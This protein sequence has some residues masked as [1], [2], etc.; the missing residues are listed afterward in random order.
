MDALEQVSVALYDALYA[1]LG[2]HD[3]TREEAVEGVR[4]A[5]WMLNDDYGID[6]GNR[7][8]PENEEPLEEEV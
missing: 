2:V 7:S 3:V 4:Q 6:T 5:I 8:I 1:M